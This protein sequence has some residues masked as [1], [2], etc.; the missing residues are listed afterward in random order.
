VIGSLDKPSSPAGEAKQHFHNRLFGRSHDQREAFRA[1]VLAV[2]VDDLRRVA[3][4]YLTGEQASTAVITS[5]GTLDKDP[6]LAQRMGLRLQE[7]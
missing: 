7:L 2:S 6:E 5:R 3:E 1:S 4:N